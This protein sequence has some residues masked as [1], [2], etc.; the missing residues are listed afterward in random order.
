MILLR[1]L[2][3]QFIELA[4]IPNDFYVAGVVEVSSAALGHRIGIISSGVSLFG[5]IE[6]RK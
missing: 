2:C 4:E 1:V 6:W 3:G 5:K